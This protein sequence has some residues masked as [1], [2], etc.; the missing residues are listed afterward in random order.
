MKWYEKYDNVVEFA[1]FLVSEL[2][3]NATQIIGFLEK[4]WKWSP[5]RA[6]FKEWQHSSILRKQE[7]MDRLLDS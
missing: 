3:F 1:A 5:E 4:P 7:L 2:G 6:L